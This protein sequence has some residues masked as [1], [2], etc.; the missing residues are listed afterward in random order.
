[1]RF[2]SGSVVACVAVAATCAAV[3]ASAQDLPR[4]VRQFS[5]GWRNE[6]PSDI[7]GPGDVGVMRA[8]AA[9]GFHHEIDEHWILRGQIGAE[10][11]RYDWSRESAFLGSNRPWGEIWKSGVALQLLYDI[12]EQWGLVT[13]ATF[14]SGAETDADFEDSLAVKGYVGFTWKRDDRLTLGLDMSVSS[15]IEDSVRILPFPV[16]DWRF[17]DDWRFVTDIGD[18]VE[19][20]SAALRRT[21]SENFE[22]GLIAFSTLNDARLND[23]GAAPNGVL[24]ET[25]L[26][27]GLEGVWKPH[28]A[29][30][31]S[32]LAGFDV[33]GEFEVADSNG[34]EID[35]TD[36]EP[37]PVFGISARLYF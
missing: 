1:M 30:Q 11:S 8:R 27:V 15:Q 33:W 35:T 19:G 3:P 7:D 34:D 20:P 37:A 9:I 28:R 36:L 31:I 32:A 22:L 24:R 29:V 17:D 12:D 5:A 18:V 10:N 6:L 25:R 13:S 23:T 16:I 14:A 21:C 26:G 4:D 2:E